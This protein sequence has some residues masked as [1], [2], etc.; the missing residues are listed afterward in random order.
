M[1]QDLGV[2]SGLVRLSFLV[3]S[4]YADVC[5]HHD[6]TPQQAQLLCVLEENNVGM[7]EL[8]KILHLEKSSLSGLV[9]RVE[10][11]G[12]VERVTSLQDARSV[13]VK[14]TKVGQS[15]AREFKAETTVRLNEVVSCMPS[16]VRKDFASIASQI[17]KEH[18][19]PAVFTD[20]NK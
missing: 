7:A 19:V 3:Q 18:S 1:T 2:A 12:F 17:V 15:L 6:L 10:I 5:E 20:G 9:N 13:S 11:R 4:V 8:A 14:L 16:S